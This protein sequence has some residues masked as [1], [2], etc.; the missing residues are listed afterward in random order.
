MIFNLVNFLSY[1]DP[2]NISLYKR[3][4]CARICLFSYKKKKKMTANEIIS[5]SFVLVRLHSAFLLQVL[6]L[7]PASSAWS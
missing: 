5:H 1:N 6:N 4:R 2:F 7:P 3:D